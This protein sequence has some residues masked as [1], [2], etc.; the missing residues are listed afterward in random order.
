MISPSNH[1]DPMSIFCI[2]ESTT[3]TSG[4]HIT[5]SINT[6]NFS[7]NGPFARNFHAE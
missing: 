6:E 5:D 1:T 2:L 4:D 7:N 3:I